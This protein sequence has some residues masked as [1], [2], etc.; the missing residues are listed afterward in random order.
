MS[1]AADDG[2]LPEA[3]K[4]K[5]VDYSWRVQ[6]AAAATTEEEEE[7]ERAPPT[8]PPNRSDSPPSSLP[9]LPVSPSDWLLS[10]PPPPPQPS[11]PSSS[12]SQP[13]GPAVAEAQAAAPAVSSSATSFPDRQLTTE[14][15]LYL[16][17][18]FYQHAKNA[19]EEAL[20]DLFWH[21]GM[22]PHDPSC[23]CPVEMDWQPDGGWRWFYNCIYAL[24]ESD[25]KGI[26]WEVLEPEDCDMGVF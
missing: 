4:G 22:G 9:S 19:M 25:M 23:A 10:P 12:S 15:Y 13:S 17:A 26:E 3:W 2:S 16:S 5:A 6:P 14:E 8:T 24:Y 18:H 21:H 11:P 7:G 20:A 1:T